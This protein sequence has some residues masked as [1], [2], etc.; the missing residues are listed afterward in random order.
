MVA[1]N[2]LSFP[3]FENVFIT[4]MTTYFSAC[5]KCCAIFTCLLWFQM[6]NLLSFELCSFMV[7]KMN[8]F[9]LEIFKIFPLSLN[10]V[11][12]NLIVM[13]C[14]SI[15]FFRIQNFL[16]FWNHRCLLPNMESVQPLLQQLHFFSSTLFLLSSWDSNGTN[17]KLFLLP[18]DF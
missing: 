10:L 11:L 1:I 3:S 18:K 9:F 2:S 14:N 17:S 7:N 13:H 6:R 16:S 4:C 8:H 5:E 12:R 15:F